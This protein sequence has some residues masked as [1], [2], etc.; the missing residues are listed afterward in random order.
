MTRV[1]KVGKLVLPR[2][3]FFCILNSGGSEISEVK[4]ISFLLVEIALQK[5]PNTEQE[6][7]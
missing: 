3:S 2:T 1:Q 7:G 5:S 4:D 6:P